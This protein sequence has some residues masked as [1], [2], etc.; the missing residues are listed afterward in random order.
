MKFYD[1]ETELSSINNML[2]LSRT[3]SKYWNCMGENEID[4][5]K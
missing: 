2:T 1:R 5:T 4:L 3:E